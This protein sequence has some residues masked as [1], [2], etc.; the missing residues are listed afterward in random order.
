VPKSVPKPTPK[1]APRPTPK[2][3]RVSDKYKG[4]AADGKGMGFRVTDIGDVHNVGS[5]HG[6]GRAVDFSVKDKSKAEVDT[7]IKEMRAKGYNVKDERT[8]PSGQ[9][10]WTGPHIYVSDT[11]P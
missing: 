10:V 8:K 7:F 1:L 5:L 9:K 2:P 4:I 11:R 6:Q 3:R